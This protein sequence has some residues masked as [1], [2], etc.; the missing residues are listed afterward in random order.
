[1]T[2]K[3]GSSEC[4]G[5][6]HGMPVMQEMALDTLFYVQR[7]HESTLRTLALLCLSPAYL[8]SLAQ[9]AVSLVQHAAHAGRV[10]PDLYL[11]FLAS[12]LIGQSSQLA[13]KLLDEGYDRAKQVVSSASRAL[14]SWPGGSGGHAPS[15]IPALQ[16]TYCFGEHA[17]MSSPQLYTCA[18]MLGV[19]DYSTPEQITAFEGMLYMHWQTSHLASADAALNH[20]APVL[21]ASISANDRS[22][23]AL[24]GSMT[25]V[26]DS[27]AAGSPVCSLADKQIPALPTQLQQ[28][29]PGA[30][31][32]Y[33]AAIASASAHWT[34][35]SA[36]T[37]DQGTG[38][39]GAASEGLAQAGSQGQLSPYPGDFAYDLLAAVPAL[40]ELFMKEL[41]ALATSKSQTVESNSLHGKSSE[42]KVLLSLLIAQK[43]MQHEKLRAALLLEISGP[44]TMIAELSAAAEGA[45]KLSSK[46]IAAARQKL[47]SLQEIHFGS[48]SIGSKR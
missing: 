19:T 20:L 33:A 46:A 31:L 35:D 3:G 27:G 25:A 15:Q 17:M 22:L 29:L 10:A 26:Q 45:A 28:C 42:E 41:A 44:C 16:K 37:G 14:Q 23:R 7:L 38:A 36:P 47:L 43:V 8:P 39:A 18:L 48:S 24:Y 13:G 1:M 2:D 40:L 9:R 12:L 5:L 34:Q 21:A 32:E 11:S 6:N 30:V 4:A